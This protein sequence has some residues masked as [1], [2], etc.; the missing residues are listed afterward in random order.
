MPEDA[1][2]TVTHPNRKPNCNGSGAACFDPWFIGGDGIVFCFH[3]KS[4]EHFSLVSDLNLQINARFIGLRPSGRT[5]DYT[6]IQALGLMFGSHNFTLEAKKARKWDNEVDHFQF[7]YDGNALIIREGHSSKWNSVYNDL[8]IERTSSKNSVIVIVPEIVEVLV[9]V[10]PVSEE[11]NQIHNYWIPCDDSFAHLEVQFRFMGLSNEV[12]G[13]LD[14]TYQPDFKNLAKVGVAMAVV[15]GED[16]EADMGGFE[17]LW[18]GRVILLLQLVPGILGWG[19]EGHY[20]ICKIAEGYLSEDASAAVKELLPDH[21]EGDLASVCS[22][23]DEIRF[24]FHWSG[25]LHYVD[26]P[27]F[28][29][30]YSYCRDCHDTAGHKN[31]CVTGAI[32]NYTMQLMS[33]SD[34][35][36]EMKCKQ[37]DRGTY[38]LI[39]FYWGC[40]SEVWDTMI[41]ESA[42]KTFYSKDL[43]IMIQ[44]IQKNITDGWSDEFLLWEGCA[45]GQTVCP[46]PYASESINLAC[47][48]AYRNATPGSTLG[49]MI[50][51]SLGFLLWRRGL[52]KAGSAWLPPSTVSSVHDR[53]SHKNEMKGYRSNISYCHKK[54]RGR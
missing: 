53:Q 29:C 54:W 20:T 23:A 11:E 25:P 13:V 4:N 14:Q 1:F 48:F 2:S 45:L 47:K 28:R 9:S 26:T 34:S 37:F 38:V 39:T 30:N 49:A 10:V 52:L 7:S 3:G 15:G 16:S 51:F 41:I 19:K 43:S 6:W 24:H 32:Y 18:I 35:N 17:V 50:T 36:S 44:A 31:R 42:L 12:D 40:P 5:C 8:T 22:W 27:D 33:Y 21:A 46:D